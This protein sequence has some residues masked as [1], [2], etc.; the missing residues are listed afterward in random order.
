LTSYINIGILIMKNK[1]KILG[2]AKSFILFLDVKFRA[3]VYR[4]IELLQEF[5]PFLKEPHSKKVRRYYN[6]YELR[7]IHGGN[8]FR[9]FYFHF[10]KNIYVITSGYMKKEN[11][12]SVSEIEKAISIK[13][14]YLEKHNG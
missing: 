11:R 8:I 1:V 4:S 7:V 2:R 9:L 6:L 5:G 10:T 13:Q 3:K 12:L 14:R